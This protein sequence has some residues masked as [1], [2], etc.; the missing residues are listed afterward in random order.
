VQLDERGAVVVDKAFRSSVE[1]IYAVGDVSNRLN[2][3]P[4]AIAEGHALADALFGPGGRTVSYE[5]VPTAVFSIP[6]IATVGCTEAEAR[7]RHGAVDIY[8]SKFRPMRHTLSG[9]DEP[10]MMKLVVARA[11]QRVVG[12]HMVG[13]DAPEIIQGIAIAVNCGATKQDFDRT[14]GIHPTAAEEFV[15]MRTRLPDP[16]RPGECD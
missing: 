3:T 12:A 16:P 6:P 8:R 9:R 14:I 11:T 10:T 15:T 4:V 2:L 1:N 7:E 5:N 13:L